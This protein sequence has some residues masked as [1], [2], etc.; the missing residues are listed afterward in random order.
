MKIDAFHYIQLGTVYRC[1]SILKPLLMHF[2][3]RRKDMAVVFGLQRSPPSQRR[4]GHR[5]VRRQPRAPGDHERLLR[6]GDGHCLV[7]FF[8]VCKNV[9]YGETRQ[10][11]LST[12]SPA[13][14]TRPHHEAVHGHLLPA[15]DDPP[16]LCQR[17]LHEAQ[18]RLRAGASVQRRKGQ[19]AI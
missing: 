10:T 17:L 5:H 4:G 19:S 6:K 1:E 14:L 8:P 11:R 9:A 15:R 16:V 12:F 2:H 3:S 7:L 18:H 13:E